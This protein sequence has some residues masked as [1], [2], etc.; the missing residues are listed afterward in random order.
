VP[1]FQRRVQAYDKQIAAAAR[2]VSQMFALVCGLD[3]DYI[4]D[5]SG[6]GCSML[7]LLH[8]P[9]PAA[10]LAQAPGS[11]T[12]YEWFALVWQS[13]PGLEVTARDGSTVAVPAPTGTLWVLVGDLV[14][15]LS[16]GLLPSTLHSVR[17]ADADRYSLTYFY[18]P[19]FDAQIAAAAPRR[20]HGSDVYPPIDAGR[21]LTGLRVR[22]I[23]HLRAAVAS[24]EL[25]LPFDLPRS[26][27]FK[28]RKERR[29]QA[30]LDASSITSQT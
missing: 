3:R 11:H 1:D 15:Q 12:D 18:G 14:E 23:A 19:D 29:V 26:N 24:G 9:V 7:R 6:R 25:V 2:R 20:K 16:G 21:H 30:A 4:A 28:T 17:P 13:A 8:Y 27:P 10:R 5:R 22:H